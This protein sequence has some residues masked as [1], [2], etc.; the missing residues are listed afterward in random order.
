MNW[1]RLLC[2]PFTR[3]YE[4]LKEWWPFSKLETLPKFVQ[5]SI[6]IL[7]SASK[8]VKD[9]RPSQHQIWRCITFR[10]G[11]SSPNWLLHIVN[12][13]LNNILSILNLDERVYVLLFEYSLDTAVNLDLEEKIV[14]WGNLCLT[15]FLWWWIFAQLFWKRGVLMENLDP[16]ILIKRWTEMKTL[17][18]VS[19][20]CRLTAALVGCI[21][22]YS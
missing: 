5:P 21:T 18:R 10:I 6:I 2:K 17:R 3:A 1:L 4:A 15:L 22:F 14:A 8:V 11:E 12:L 13:Y 7:N 19:S 20:R 16:I 9:L